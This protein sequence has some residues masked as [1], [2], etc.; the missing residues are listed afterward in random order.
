MTEIT[1]IDCDYLGKERMAAVYL[2]R[3]DDELAFI[4]NNTH[5]VLPKLLDAVSATGRSPED[6]KYLIIT[7]VHLDHAGGTSALAAACPNAT[8]L[9]H[10][11]AARHV[12]D[13]SK[14]VASATAVYGAD[15][16]ERLYGTIVGVDEA[17]VRA[18]E[19]EETVRLGGRMLRFLHTRGHANHH[20]VVWDETSRSVFSG[21]AFGLTY[22]VLQG[23]GPFTFPSSSPTDFDAELARG[24]VDRIV[25]LDPETVYPTHFGAVRD[26]RTAAAQMKRH[27]DFYE[28]VM[29]DAFASDLPDD[30]LTDGCA[31]RLRDYFAGLLNQHGALGADPATW[32]W[33]KLDLDLNAQG[34]AFAAVKKRKQAAGG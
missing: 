3:D 20:F 11:R 16:F 32:D 12:I 28:T 30:A 8:V 29:E 26:V 22:P 18:M 23:P 21:D 7:H 17:R 25:A 24:S 33:L 2:L 31:R 6:V 27:L 4:D 10:P 13:P 14:L 15:E 5:A 9:A 1:T 34:L 19:D